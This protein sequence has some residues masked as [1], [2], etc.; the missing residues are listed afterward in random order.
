MVR[1]TIKAFTRETTSIFNPLMKVPDP[2]KMIRTIILEKFSGK[3]CLLWNFKRGNKM[4]SR[5]QK[6][7]AVWQAQ[8]LTAKSSILKLTTFTTSS[9]I[10]MIKILFK[11]KKL[12]K[13]MCQEFNV[14]MTR[15]LFSKL[16]QIKL[17]MKSLVK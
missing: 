9:M 10:S 8:N 14:R 13:N 7:R 17:E 3:Q 5:K 6:V 16:I 1:N 11:L 2:T 4:T 12:R 15:K